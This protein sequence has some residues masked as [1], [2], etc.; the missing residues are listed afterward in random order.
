MK[1]PTKL[2]EGP[3]A[4][5]TRRRH[6]LWCLLLALA[7]AAV[8]AALVDRAEIDDRTFNGVVR[9]MQ[10]D[11]QDAID[12]G[13]RITGSTPVFPAGFEC[14]GIDD[15]WA[16]DYS[17]KRARAAL[18][19]GI[20]I[21]APH[22]TPI[23]AVADGTVVAM[24]DNHVTAVGVRIFL[25][26]APGQTGKPFWTYSE[27]AHL[28]ELPALQIGSQVKRGEVVGLTSN[29]GISGQEARAKAGAP[30]SSTGTSKAR[31]S[32]LHFSIM[33]SDSPDYAVLPRHGGSLV[34]VRARWMDPVAFYRSGPPYDS[35][36]L[37][38]LDEG[39]KQVQIPFQT[40]EGKLH[41]AETRLIWPYPCGTR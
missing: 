20:D 14:R 17:A 35:D 23:L 36:A 3:L 15:G 16:I 9:C 32:A 18:H 8:Q 41:P 24:F 6:W 21:P 40:P 31:R 38:N 33:Y 29:T 1:T 19:G 7:P 25:Q 11:L 22:G 26:H 12:L 10:C 39:K 30:S 28:R 4:Q 2:N 5:A 34:P 37:A 27:Y 13:M